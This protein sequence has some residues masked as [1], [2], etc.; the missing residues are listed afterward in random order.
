MSSI[1]CTSNVTVL[2]TV[3]QGSLIIKEYLYD[4]KLVLN[5]RISWQ[6]GRMISIL[7]HS[8][9]DCHFGKPFSIGTKNETKLE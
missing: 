8:I 7:L 3:Y 5:P 2:T 9:A 4:N 6:L 1:A